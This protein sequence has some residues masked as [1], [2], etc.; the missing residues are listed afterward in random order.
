MIIKP[1]GAHGR[2]KVKALSDLHI[3]AVGIF[4]SGFL[5][6]HLSWD[7]I[8]LLSEDTKQQR[9]TL[10][11]SISQGALTGCRSEL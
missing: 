9:L 11:S 4:L 1:G 6:V 10:V 2:L 8:L 5:G 7:F 3:A